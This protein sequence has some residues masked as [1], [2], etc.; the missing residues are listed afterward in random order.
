M[1][2][3]LPDL[4]LRPDFII[5]GALTLR[6][7]GITQST[8]TVGDPKAL[9]LEYVQRIG[10]VIDLVA[11]A[12][13]ALRAL[14]LGAGAMTLPRYIAATRPGSTQIVIELD[15]TLLA[16]VLDRLPLPADAVIDIVRGDAFAAVRDIVASELAPF[17][18]IVVDIYA[19]L[20]PPDYV[21]DGEFFR[22]LELLRAPGGVI[23]VNVVDTRH[24]TDLRAGYRAMEHFVPAVIAAGPN[25]LISGKAS[26]NAIL[27]G[28]D[29]AVVEGMIRELNS[30]GP[31]PAA[32]LGVDAARAKLG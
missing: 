12:G 15:E 28:G 27:V 16:L 1:A 9:H 20:A 22:D 26:G 25:Y 2:K 17:D 10:N 21:A 29:A 5:P 31:H 18:V 32:A 24:L 7:D 6:V 23:I 3:E 14:H 13:Q 11:P 30:R 19:A 8:V 4:E